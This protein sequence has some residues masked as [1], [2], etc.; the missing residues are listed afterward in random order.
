M[1][2]FGDRRLKPLEAAA[3]GTGLGLAAL[4]LGRILSGR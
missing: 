1:L 4:F 3:L 2:T